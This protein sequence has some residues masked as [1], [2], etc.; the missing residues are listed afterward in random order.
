[1]TRARIVWTLHNAARDGAEV[2]I[3]LINGGVAFV[4][5]LAVDADAV[6]VRQRGAFPR[7]GRAWSSK[8]KLSDV[9]R[10][11]RVET[12]SATR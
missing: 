5:V 1:M 3:E 9:R 12:W 11:A 10:A 2:R 4:A 6:D 8:I 7:G